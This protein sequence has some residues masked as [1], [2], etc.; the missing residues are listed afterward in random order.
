MPSPNRPPQPPDVLGSSG[1]GTLLLE[2]RAQLL[3]TPFSR[4]P[5]SDCSNSEPYL[6]R[7]TEA[8]RR[9]SVAA[10]PLLTSLSSI[11]ASVSEHSG[12]ILVKLKDLSR[13]VANDFKKR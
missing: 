11:G 8:Q 1:D 13:W 10:P 7:R 3:T 12:F 2:T 4:H 5:R 6:L 9:Q